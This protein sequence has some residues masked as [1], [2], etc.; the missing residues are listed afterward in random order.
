MLSR[1]RQVTAAFTA[2]VALVMATAS[3]SSTQATDP[4][5]SPDGLIRKDL[6]TWALPTDSYL[7][8]PSGL[9]L[10][11]SQV[12]VAQCMTGRGESFTP[13]IYDWNAPVPAT[14]NA[15]GR[16]LFDETIAARYGYHTAPDPSGFQRAM[17]EQSTFLDKQSEAW[18]GVF[19]ACW[20]QEVT[21]DPIF[22]DNGTSQEFFALSGLDDPRVIE[23]AKTW[24]ECMAPLGIPDLPDMPTSM[25]ADSLAERFG[26]AAVDPVNGTDAIDVSAAEIEVAVHDAQC[27]HS[28]GF[29]E[30]YYDVEW[31]K[32]TD[33]VATHLTDLSP[34][35]E[36]TLAKERAMKDIIRSYGG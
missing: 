12:K 22:D 33:Y 16:R 18:L 9:L 10:S 8:V 13:L 21:A 7:N 29:T 14:A 36:Q 2:A 11:A 32:D 17:R 3:C 31:E 24:R 30:T 35:R 28:S 1:V 19:S 23:A 20:D 25:P 27:R 15:S 26:L 6:A 5:L 34:I 4:D